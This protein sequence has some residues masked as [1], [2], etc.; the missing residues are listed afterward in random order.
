MGIRIHKMIGYA[1]TDVKVDQYEI[2]DKRFNLDVIKRL[3]GEAEPELNL[4]GYY[5]W[6]K[7]EVS[8][9]TKPENYSDGR[10]LE[11][12]ITN[13]LKGK[14][15]DIYH[16]I[17]HDAEY[18]HPNV[19]CIIPLESADWNRHD[20]FLD[21]MEET[22][23]SR[24]SLEPYFKVFKNGIWP[25]NGIYMNKK[26]G[27]RLTVKEEAAYNYLQRF[28]NVAFDKDKPIKELGDMT[29]RQVESL[30]KPMVPYSIRNFCEYL[31]IFKKPETVFSLKPIM[32][33]YWG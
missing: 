26:T 2:V 8:L 9:L 14:A 32:Y 30:Y 20:D 21:Y 18:G 31:K 4:K 10:T 5:K 16:H 7:K 13:N 6:V 28:K 11:L 15:G 23:K 12:Q 29:Y 22:T 33:V 1:L 19:F 17:I 24:K 25:Y 27:E 3:K